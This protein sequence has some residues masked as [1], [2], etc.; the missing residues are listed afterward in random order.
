MEFKKFNKRKKPNFI[1][2][3]VLVLLLFIIVY[4]WMHA[5][6]LVE[7]LFSTKP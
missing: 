6:Q 7:M 1:R 3:I 4:L 2:G 5:E